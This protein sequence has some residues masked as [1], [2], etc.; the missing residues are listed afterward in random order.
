M[1]LSVSSFLSIKHFIY[2][3]KSL[4]QSTYCILGFHDSFFMKYKSLLHNTHAR[5]KVVKLR[6][7]THNPTVWQPLPWTLN[8]ILLPEI[9]PSSDP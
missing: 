5:D 9:R 1:L 7:S 4:N 2:A 8:T 6:I 3:I